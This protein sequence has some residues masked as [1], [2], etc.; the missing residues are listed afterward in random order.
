MIKTVLNIEGM[1]CGMC[2]AHINDAIR[3]T[4]MVKKITSSHVKG[5]TE[6]LTE[7]PLD[8]AQLKNT[9]EATGYNV[10]DIHTE[11]YEK[12]GFSLFRK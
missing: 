9:V 12:K 11:T 1:A 4:F 5:T 7:I 8:R 10:T 6:I 3:K 2:E